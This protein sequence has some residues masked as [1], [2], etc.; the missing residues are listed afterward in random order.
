MIPAPLADALGHH[1]RAVDRH[2]R[3]RRAGRGRVARRRRRVS[4]AACR[5]AG[6]DERPVARACSPRRTGPS[7]PVR[8][9]RCT[10]ARRTPATLDAARL[11]ASLGDADVT[12][13]RHGDG[14]VP[15][16][17]LR[18]RR[19]RGGAR[20]RRRRRGRGRSRAHR[21]RGRQ[22]LHAGRARARPGRRPTRRRRPA[23]ACPVLLMD[24]RGIT[25]IGTRPHRRGRRDADDRATSTTPRAA[26]GSVS[27]TPTP[28][29]SSTSSSRGCATCARDDDVIRYVVGPTVAAHAGMGTFG[30]VYHP[31]DRPA[32]TGRYDHVGRLYD[33]VSLEPLYRPSRAPAAG[34]GRRSAPG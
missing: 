26:C 10:S 16:R 11:G 27:A 23:T 30:I 20:R 7:A 22:R 21:Q 13:R 6:D 29:P 9:C 14:V 5:R 15:R 2:H 25:P 3:R 28:D 1:G 18:A 31:L 12:R 8:S 24:R 17:L 19:G 33:I 4:P 34:A 32:V